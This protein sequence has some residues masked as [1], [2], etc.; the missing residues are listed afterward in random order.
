[1]KRVLTSAAILG[2]AAL[3]SASGAFARSSASICPS[4]PLAAYVT[5][6]VGSDPI[7]GS[8]GTTTWAFGSYTR[9]LL[10]YRYGATTFCAMWRDY[11]SFTTVAGPSPGGTGLVAADVSGRM[12]R[13]TVSTVFD[14]QWKGTAPTRGSLD[15]SGAQIDWLQLYFD[16]VRGLGVAYAA[17]LFQ[18]A[19]GCWSYKFG[20]PDTGDI[21]TTKL[22]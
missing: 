4:A 7:A 2:L 14:A 15:T 5:Y 9:T 1:M 11:G 21:V 10:I 12:I 3:A 8:S 13:N 19:Y 6:T 20:A 18:S 17:G 16:N 22:V